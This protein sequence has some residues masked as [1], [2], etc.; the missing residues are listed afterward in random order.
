MNYLQP[1][2]WL[3]SSAVYSKDDILIVGLPKTAT[4]WL[5]TVLVQLYYEDSKSFDQVN[6]VALEYG[7]PIKQIIN[8]DRTRIIKTHRAKNIFHLD[9]RVKIGLKRDILDNI[10]S[11]YVYSFAKKPSLRNFGFKKFVINNN[12]VEWFVKFYCSWDSCIDT[13]L[14]FDDIQ[15]ENYEK[16]SCALAPKIGY[17]PGL[18]HSVM[19]ENNKESSIRKSNMSNKHKSKFIEGF[20]FV[21]ESELKKEVRREIP[22]EDL[23]WLKKLI[24][25]KQKR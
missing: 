18:V 6:S 15:A 2:R 25:E 23:V 17:D 16:L 8:S 14:D 21:G 13:W 1:I 11:Y 12:V 3:V 20:Q 5:K 4:T 9:H 19:R 7:S 10:V 22:N 24:E